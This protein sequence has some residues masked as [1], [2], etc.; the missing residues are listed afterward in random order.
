MLIAIGYKGHNS[1]NLKLGKDQQTSLLRIGIL[2]IPVLECF[3][4]I[5]HTPV[6]FQNFL[7]AQFGSKY[8]A[9]FA[10]LTL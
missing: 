9:N 4:S 3:V 1:Q 8:N 7:A 2:Y 6:T 10:N 5:K